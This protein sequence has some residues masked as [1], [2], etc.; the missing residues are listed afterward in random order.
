VASFGHLAG[1]H[2]QNEH[3]WDPYI[4]RLERGEPPI[5]RALTPTAEERLIRELILQFKLGHLRASY[6]LR[7]FGVDIRKRFAAALRTL[8]DEEVL[9]EKGDEIR[10]T[11]TGLLQ[12]DRLVHEFFLPQHRDAR[13]A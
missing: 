2:Y 11:R 7:K 1:T 8:R 12:V 5:Y 9:L 13:Y 10:L 4:R 3:D 6:F